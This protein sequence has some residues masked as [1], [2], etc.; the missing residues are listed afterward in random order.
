MGTWIEICAGNQ[1]PRFHTRRSLQWERGLKFFFLLFFD[2]VLRRS[3]QW[4]RGLK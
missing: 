4:E 2:D 1:L 3:L